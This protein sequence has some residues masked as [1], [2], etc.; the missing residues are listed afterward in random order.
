MNNFAD[1]QSAQTE[2]RT[3]KPLRARDFESDP[4]VSTDNNLATPPS[5]AM[6]SGVVVIRAMSRVLATDLATAPLAG[7]VQ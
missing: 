1:F 7:V 2:G 5:G 4:A 3:R 6:S